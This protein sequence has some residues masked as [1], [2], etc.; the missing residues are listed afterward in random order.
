MEELLLDEH[1]Q[2]ILVSIGCGA[3]IGLEREYRNK[4]A[5]FRT[6]ILICFGATIFAMISKMGSHSDDRVAANI[7][8][9]IGF[10]GAGVIYQGK[11]SVLGLTTAAVIWTMAAIGMLIGFGEFKLGIVMTILM[12]TILSVF[13]NIEDLLAK[14]HFTRT[15]HITFTDNS[16]SRLYEFEQFLLEQKIRHIRKG[17]QKDENQLVVAYDVSGSRKR[18]RAMNERI[19]SLEYV[20]TFNNLA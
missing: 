19:I 13:Q 4:S 1:V 8:T 12:V 14:I 10:I 11:F 5:G 18:M 6:V 9:G 2:S 17:M 3:V 20:Y 7:V 15:I 16:V